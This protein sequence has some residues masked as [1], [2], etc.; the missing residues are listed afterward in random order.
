MVKTITIATP[1]H[2]DMLNVMKSEF[3]AKCKG[4]LYV[5]NSCDGYEGE[6]GTRDFFEVMLFKVRSIIDSLKQLGEGDY[7]IYLDSDI[8]IR[9]DIVTEMTKEIRRRNVDIML[10]SDD[11]Y[12]CAGMFICKCSDRITNLFE[13]VLDLLINNR[14]HYA[15]L[16]NDQTALYDAMTNPKNGISYYFLSRRFTTYG[17]LRRDKTAQ[18]HIGSERFRLPRD[19]VAFHAN[20]TVGIENK[21]ALLKYVRSARL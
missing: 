9:Q 8:Y 13:N 1:M 7:M 6:F 18:W 19:L 3:H 16:N 5:Y 15:A 12:P 14:E 21:E 11:G 20:F 2:V 17:N 10:Q 4:D